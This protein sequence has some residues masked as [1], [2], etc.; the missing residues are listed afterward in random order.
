[1]KLRFKF[2]I[3]ILPLTATVFLSPACRREPAALSVSP[4]RYDTASLPASI[5]ERVLK[6]DSLVNYYYTA[7]ADSSIFY[8]QMML[9]LFDSANLQKYSF[10]T[11]FFLSEIYLYRKPDDY[12]AIYYYAEALKTMLSEPG[13]TLHNP[14]FLIDLGNVL[15]RL[16][17]FQHA[18]PEYRHAA[19]IAS[20]IHDNHALAVALNN[21][22]LCYQQLQLPDTA[23]ILFLHA[24]A[25]RKT[26]MPL[27]V[28]H[29]ELYLARLAFEMNEPDTLEHYLALT[30]HSAGQQ[31]FDQQFTGVMS[32]A[33]ARELHTGILAEATYLA[34]RSQEAKN[35]EKARQTYISAA[36]T[37]S[38]TH[39]ESLKS[40]IYQ[41]LANLSLQQN[42]HREA[43]A[44][45]DSSLHPLLVCNNLRQA[46]QVLFFIAHR[47][48]DPHET[49]KVNHYLGRAYLYAD[50][51]IRK[52]NSARVLSDRLM[53]ITSRSQQ[54][55]QEYEM[56]QKASLASLTRQKLLIVIL[57]VV[58]L[59]IAGL[60]A[61]VSHQRKL[62][63][64]AYRNLVKRMA[65]TVTEENNQNHTN[66]YIAAS[67]ENSPIAEKLNRLM[68]SQKPYINPGLTLGD[69]AN[70]LDT[71]TA[72]LS[73]CINQKMKCN[74]HDY[75][76]ALR[77]K[78]A[79]RVF[80]S[81]TARSLSVDQVADQ[82]GFSSRSTF[83]IAFKK[84][85][86]ITP[87]FYQK[88]VTAVTCNFIPSAPENIKNVD[89]A[90]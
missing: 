29:N 34:G 68:N 3:S 47:C 15:Y 23:K 43:L 50:S 70:Q 49:A 6:L 59:V 86:G 87:A 73:Q 81:D 37:A 83:Y 19:R 56:R 12:K 11:R 14:Y 64:Q 2:G 28:A 7:N 55:L 39:L 63:L 36:T 38:A 48:I 75:V 57:I 25:I 16:S 89:T 77:V 74:F 90:G 13:A 69:L 42:N 1:M 20:G 84:F 46:S 9:H 35:T 76:N 4:Y 18:L 82:V 5:K 17:L 45:A 30:F 85:T 31:K 72:Y 26:L 24:L 62:T 65:E 22:A 54:T 61:M 58:V 66:S 32:L 60:L 80:Q 79:C 27:L 78:E 71:N 21:Q 41:A 10:N 67:W 8:S 51:L 44:Y 52:E 40:D 53:L 33:M 88:H